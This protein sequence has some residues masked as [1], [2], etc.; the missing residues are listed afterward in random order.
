MIVP[1]YMDRSVIYYSMRDIHSVLLVWSLLQDHHI[2]VV[3]RAMCTRIR[4]LSRLGFQYMH[5]RHWRKDGEN[6]A[7]PV[8]KRVV[9]CHG[10]I[11]DAS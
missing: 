5:V 8:E 7:P 11:V 1:N 10:Q 4:F 6:R 9:F 3:K 2:H